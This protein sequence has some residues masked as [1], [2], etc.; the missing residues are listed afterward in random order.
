MYTNPNADALQT[1][2]GGGTYNGMDAKI[3]ALEKRVE[4][5][6][7]KLDVIAKEVVDLRVQTATLTE[8]ITH[9]PSKEFIF[10][11]IA[12]LVAAMVAVSVLSP[13]LQA[14]FGVVPH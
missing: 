8:R 11:G 13:K 4:K 6:E 3:E 9:L 12:G 5:F 10:K 2:G 7:S 1:G 14:L